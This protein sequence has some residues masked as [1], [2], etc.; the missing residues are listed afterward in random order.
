MPKPPDVPVWVH[1]PAIAK[2]FA[3]A[4]TADFT[5][6]KNRAKALGAL[7]AKDA[8]IVKTMHVLVGDFARALA[9]KWPLTPAIGPVI[10]E[11]MLQLRTL[12]AALRYAGV[13]NDA[14][15]AALVTSLPDHRAGVVIARVLDGESLDLEPGGQKEIATLVET[16]RALLQEA[17]VAEYRTQPA[18]AIKRWRAV[19]KAPRSEEQ[20]IAVIRAI[21]EALDG[22]FGS[23]AHDIVVLAHHDKKKIRNVTNAMIVRRPEVLR[24]Y[25]AWVM[26]QETCS[27]DVIANLCGRVDNARSFGLKRKDYEA[28]LRLLSERAGER[29]ERGSVSLLTKALALR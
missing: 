4:M 8:A 15:L 12:A 25:L 19:L 13:A 20:A 22:R 2:A 5:L 18:K 26:K 3:R 21:E 6:Q 23:W 24:A 7:I 10:H 16:G 28:Q 11:R 9:V 27:K 29:G 14:K 17:L 1:P